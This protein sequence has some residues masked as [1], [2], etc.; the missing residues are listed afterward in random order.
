M[1][2]LGTFRNIWYWV[3]NTFVWQ[4]RRTIFFQL[5][6]RELFKWAAV[7]QVVEQVCWFDPRLLLA[8]VSIS[9]APNPNC[10]R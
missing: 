2:N 10:S 8:E 6:K 7:A 4:R 3:M 9:K 5:M 1:D